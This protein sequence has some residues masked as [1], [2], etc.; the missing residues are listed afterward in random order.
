MVSFCKDNGITMFQKKAKI[1]IV[2]FMKN[3]ND[4]NNIFG[5]SF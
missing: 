2:F 3:S 5:F 4:K 1:T